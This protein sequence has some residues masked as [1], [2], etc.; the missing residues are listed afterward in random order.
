MN[1]FSY[2]DWSHAIKDTIGS[3]VDGA[4]DLTNAIAGKKA[5]KSDVFGKRPPNNNPSTRGT[6]LK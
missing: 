5:P 4:V 6:Q 2:S 3:G 1:P